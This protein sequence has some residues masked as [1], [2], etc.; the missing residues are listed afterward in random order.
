MPKRYS[1]YILVLLFG[2]ALLI[3]SRVIFA[4][5]GSD[6]TVHI[7]DIGQGDAILI[8]L[9]NNEQTLI[10][11]GP[12]DA[13]LTQISKYMPPFDRKIEHVVL[14][15]PHADHVTG[16]VKVVERYEVGEVLETGID[17]SSAIYKRWRDDI[18]N[19]NIPDRQI[20]QGEEYLWGPARFEVLWPDNSSVSSSSDSG[21]NNTSVVGR[22]VFGE[23]EVM[24]MGDAEKE[25]QERLCSF[26]KSKLESDAIK[27]AHH[28]SSNGVSE[29]LFKS[30]SAETA[31][32][33]AGK[34]NKYGHPHAEALK[35]ISRYVYKILRTDEKGTI[36][37]AMDG[38]GV[39]CR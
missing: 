39:E 34:G 5:S 26:D 19:K 17:Y 35:L 31:V 6:I 30:I 7:L 29:C 33:S 24:L 4:D 27:V 12:D 21:I 15:H 13:V 3:W 22:L 11:G 28:G 25:V 16:L 18:K 32:I 38:Q 9:P 20:R 2:V 1:F 8:S 23:S 36:S 37:C 10:D 14:T